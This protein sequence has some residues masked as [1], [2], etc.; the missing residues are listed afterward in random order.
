MAASALPLAALIG[1]G[2]LVLCEAVAWWFE[3]RTA[4]PPGI[5]PRTRLATLA[6]VVAL[7]AAMT[8]IVAAIATLPIGDAVV[9]AA[10]GAAAV[11]LVAVVL[12]RLAG[13]A[14][15]S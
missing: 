7:A 9:L 2:L 15:R 11:T 5:P 8:A 13:A 6:T 3:S 1:I 10:S 12:L 14:S 4:Q